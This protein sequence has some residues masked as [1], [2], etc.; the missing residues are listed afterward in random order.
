MSI[1]VILFYELETAKGQVSE[2]TRLEKDQALNICDI[3]VN[4][5]LHW[6]ILLTQKHWPF[7]FLV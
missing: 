6:N 3:F 2:N 5:K 1:V 4:L 7:C